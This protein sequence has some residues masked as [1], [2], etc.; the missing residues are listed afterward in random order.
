MKSNWQY[1]LEK[2][3]KS[4]RISKEPDTSKYPLHKYSYFYRNLFG[5]KR[6][7]IQGLEV[8]L[9]RFLAIHQN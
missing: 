6:E 2:V 5:V 3:Q 9:S 7:K 8:Y 1:A 4:L